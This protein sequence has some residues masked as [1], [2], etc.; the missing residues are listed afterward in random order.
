VARPKKRRHLL[1]LPWLRLLSQH[2]RPHLPLW[3]LTL[4][5]HL[6]MLPHL[7]LLTLLL[8]LLPSNWIQS[9]KATFGWFFF[10]CARPLKVVFASAPG[11]QK[12]V[13]PNRHNRQLVFCPEVNPC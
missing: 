12:P 9:K 2:L 8:P 10:A 5:L 3:R 7:L 4:L 6:L 11:C 1:P 13:D